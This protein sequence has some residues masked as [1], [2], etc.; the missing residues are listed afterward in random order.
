MSQPLSPFTVCFELENADTSKINVPLELEQGPIKFGIINL[1]AIT[2]TETEKELEVLFMVDCSG[3]MSDKC[4]D[5]RSKMQHIIHTLQNMITFFVEKPEININIT[6]TAFDTQIYPIVLRT[7]INRTNMMSVLNKIDEIRPKGNTDIGFALH[8]SGEYIYELM[9]EHCDHVYHHI[10]MTDGEATTGLTDVKELS[11]YIIKTINNSFIGFGLQHDSIIMDGISSHGK[12]AYY[13]IDKLESAG[14]VYGEIL[15]GIVYNLLTDS[16]IYIN[17]G[18]VYNFKMN[19]WTNRLLVGD[20][21]SETNKTFNIISINPLECDVT[22]RAKQD[23]T[24]VS[25]TATPIENTSLVS[26][27]Y[28]LRTLQLLYKVNDFCKTWKEH[29]PNIMLKGEL[30]NFMEEMKSY[31]DDMHLNNDKFLKNLCDDIYIC[32][33]TLGTKYAAMFCKARQ[34]SQGNQR[35]YTVSNIDEIVNNSLNQYMFGSNHVFGQTPLRHNRNNISL[36]EYEVHLQSVDLGEYQVELEH[37][38]S[39]FCDT[40]YLTQQATQIMRY[41]SSS[42]GNVADDEDDNDSVMT[43]SMF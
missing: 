38:V 19:E 5:G 37:Q 34:L 15:H 36:D 39:D 24:I 27:I 31:M 23:G 7:K 32:Y 16:T 28:R 40:P 25:Y 12:C 8:H 42:D 33:K 29:R 9:T 11:H 18:L 17:G 14:L 41:V 10:F 21:V 26:Q 35:L 30:F 6:V 43:Q 4:S 20:I 1:Q 22:I 3:S 2:A 13:F